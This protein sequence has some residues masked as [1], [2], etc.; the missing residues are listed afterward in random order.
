MI[1]RFCDRCNQ[2]IIDKPVSFG[3]AVKS[4]VINCLGY[5][6]PRYIIY[7][8]YD[9]NPRLNNKLELCQ[10][11]NEDLINWIFKGKKEAADNDSK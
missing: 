2:E 8:N 7:T 6:E 4:A 10:N 9:N 1:K 11:C 3:E 5:E